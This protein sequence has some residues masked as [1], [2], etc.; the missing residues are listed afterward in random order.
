MSKKQTPPQQKSGKVVMATDIV[1]EVILVED[2]EIQALQEETISSTDMADEGWGEA[3]SQV[4][5]A[6]LGEVVESTSVPF[7]ELENR[8]LQRALGN[9]TITFS[10]DDD[11][12]RQVWNEKYFE[13]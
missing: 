12:P 13:E 2:P 9:K 4:R 5:K 7:E 8:Q 3:T 1:E 10:D 11:T 6:Q